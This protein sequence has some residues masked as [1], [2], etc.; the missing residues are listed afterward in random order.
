[1]S[2]L[3]RI[4]TNL[5]EKEFILA[6]LMDMK[7]TVEEGDFEIGGFGGQ[8]ARVQIKIKR[9]LSND[10]GLKLVKGS[11][12]VVADWWG[13]HGIKQADFINQLSRRYAYH[14]TRSKLQAQGF[15]LVSEN[16][17]QDGQVR[18]VLRRMA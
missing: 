16:V 8:K 13:V 10:I 17:E 7:C 2:H 18:L 5:V 9:P 11:F 1:M 12:E 4:K 3:T 6:A 14:A 15:D